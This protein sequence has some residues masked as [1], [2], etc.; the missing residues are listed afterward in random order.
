MILACVALFIICSCVGSVFWARRSECHI[1]TSRQ[2]PT[3][4]CALQS[5]YISRTTTLEGNS[6]ERIV[7]TNSSYCHDYHVTANVD[8]HRHAEAKTSFLP[9]KEDKLLHP[10]KSPNQAITHASTTLCLLRLSHSV[11]SILFNH[12]LK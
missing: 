12:S 4:Q 1:E 10:C 2:S 11:I 3:V 8:I 7:P 6:L 9:C 5:S